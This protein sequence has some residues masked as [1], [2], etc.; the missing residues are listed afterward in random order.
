[1]KSL[2]S[3][4]FCTFSLTTFSQISDVAYVDFY[5][6]TGSSDGINY[7]AMIV[8]EDFLTVSDPVSVVRVKYTVDG[9][10]KIAEFNASLTYETFDEFVDVYYMGD[11][12]ASF[13]KGSGGYTPDNFMVTYDYEGAYLEGYQADHDELAK[14]DDAVVADLTSIF[15]AD[16]DHFRELI[17]EFY[18]SS[19]ELYRPLMQYAA[20]F[21]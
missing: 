5:K 4:L 21:D 10:T 15:V 14:G 19:D 13:I 16:A 6:W 12:S 9:I 1:M 18:T 2:L 17:K 7:T 8:S 11:E 20:N 3:I